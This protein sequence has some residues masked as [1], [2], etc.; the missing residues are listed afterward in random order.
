MPSISLGE[1]ELEPS[2]PGTT[3]ILANG[4]VFEITGMPGHLIVVRA[5]MEKTQW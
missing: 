4:P 5:T 1:W 3:Q 2:S